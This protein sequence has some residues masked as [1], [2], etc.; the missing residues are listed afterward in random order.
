M[1]TQRGAADDTSV[2]P[3]PIH[4]AA[5]TGPA[6]RGIPV[7][8]SDPPAP[9]RGE[10][11][12]A[13]PDGFHRL[14]PLTPFLR[15]WVIV[16]AFAATVGR[17]LAEDVT[18]RAIGLTMIFLIPAAGLYGYTAWRFTRY[19]IERDDLRLDT[20]LL[21]RRTRYVRL[22]RLQ[23]VDIVQPLLARF[24]GLA[25]LRL[26]LAGRE[27]RERADGDGG[28]AASDL[29][30]LSLG[31]AHRLRATLLTAAAGLGG[32]AP[33]APH[34]RLA[35][36]PPRRLVAAIALSPAPWVALFGAV[37]IAVPSLLTGTRAGF[38]GAVPLL[39]WLWHRTIRVFAAGYPYTVSTSPN[40]LRIDSGLLERAHA[41][42]PPGRVQAISVVEPL[43]W[44]PFG[45]ATI[46]MNVAGRGPSVLLPVARR[47]DAL[48]LVGRLLPGVDLGRVRLDRPPRRAVLLAPLHWWALACGADD[49]AF[50]SR[51]GLL[52]R[53]TDVIAHAKVQSIRMV[54]NPLVRV[55]GLA[56]VQLDT[57]GGPVRVKAGLRGREE[58][59]RIVAAQ[60]ERSRLGR[61]RAVPGAEP[62]PGDGPP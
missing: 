40:G 13:A 46:R 60:A 58:A 54:A 49:A 6:G 45:W 47:A 24:T 11:P 15:G 35:E 3:V 43:L 59:L 5:T 38:L 8:R 10:A 1:T 33:E 34:Q 32:D 16:A 17:N 7:P 12:A 48:D 52:R 27:H 30:Y 42:I 57:T 41:T 14:H 18:A 61:R 37:A 53:H 44:R 36:V 31:H 62:P 23:S 2:A 21:V 22:D 55:L 4:P 39:G 50:V 19:R 26:D 20:G 28:E 56:D 25:I 9:V 29:R 51:H